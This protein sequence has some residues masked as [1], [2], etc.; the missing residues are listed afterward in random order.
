MN[1]N[2]NSELP[3]HPNV[4]TCRCE[5]NAYGLTLLPWDERIRLQQPPADMASAP[6]IKGI[7]TISDRLVPV[8]DLREEAGQCADRSEANPLLLVV[9]TDNGA[10]APMALGLLVNTVNARF[11]LPSDLILDLARGN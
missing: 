9:T 4:L 8:F 5:G 7:I 6:R 3:T 2:G 1:T 10:T 11:R